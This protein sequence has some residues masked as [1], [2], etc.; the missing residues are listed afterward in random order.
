MWGLQNGVLMGTFLLTHAQCWT[1][2]VQE[3]QNSPQ[4]CSCR[5][6]NLAAEIAQASPAA[7]VL[8]CVADVRSGLQNQLPL[9]GGDSVSSPSSVIACALFRDAASS[10]IVGAR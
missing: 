8:V 9:D 5:C 7:R 10:V 2:I 1:I 3:I 4:G 6:L